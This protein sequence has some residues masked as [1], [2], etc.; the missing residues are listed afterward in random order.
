MKEIVKDLRSKKDFASKNSGGTI[1]K[2]DSGIKN[3]SSILSKSKDDY[4]LV[5]NCNSHEREL[6][7]H[8]SEEVSIETIL[9]DNHEDF[10]SSFNE[11]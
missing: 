11:I 3:A 5:S 1:L 9:A 7:I 4:L 2:A 6:L 8:L 10:S